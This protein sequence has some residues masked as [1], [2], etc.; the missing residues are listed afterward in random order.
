MSLAVYFYMT[1][2]SIFKSGTSIIQSVNVS[3]Q[4]DLEP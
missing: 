2:L 4:S 3:Y 1:G